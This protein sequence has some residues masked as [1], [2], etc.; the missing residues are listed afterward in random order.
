MELDYYSDQVESR[1][2][3]NERKKQIKQQM[4]KVLS[5]TV[6][7]LFFLAYLL[8]ANLPTLLPVR[9]LKFDFSIYNLREP[10]AVTVGKDG[11]LYVS[12]PVNHRVLVFDANGDLLKRLTPV[13]GKG[14]VS[15][16]Y[17]SAV[18]DGKNRIYVADFVQRAVHVFNKK[19]KFLF[20]FP[21]N[22]LARAYGEN[23]F[24][25]LDIELYK[26]R[27]FVTTRN[28]IAIFNDKGKLQETWGKKRGKTFGEFDFPNGIAINQ[29]NGDIYVA[30]TL[31]RRVV[32]M[33]KKGQVKWAVGRPDKASKLSSF[34]SLPK[35][36]ALDNEGR[37][38]VADTFE[39]SLV[40]L[41]PDGALLSILGTRGVEDAKFNFP[42]GIT[43]NNGRLIVSDKG[44]ARIQVFS[45]GGLLPKPPKRKGEERSF[46]NSLFKLENN[47]Y[48]GSVKPVRY[49]NE[50]PAAGQKI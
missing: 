34:F 30:D 12:E 25:P 15:G 13:K 11:R 14:R 36:I 49:V 18:D 23:G 9:G 46:R 20:R 10:S 24:I 38:I 5:L 50:K 27:I 47:A 43:Y 16:P 37:I 32:A 19:G 6:I 22:A 48:L 2:V 17:G 39:H 1:A 8:I 7:L 21:D 44:N 28:G 3:K 45:I 42:E 35:G 4:V 26:N 29:K 40:V 33:N 31:N 41:S